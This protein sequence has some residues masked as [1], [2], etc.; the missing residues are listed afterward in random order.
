MTYFFFRVPQEFKNQPVNCMNIFLILL[1]RSHFYFIYYVFW[2][3]YKKEI[4]QVDRAMRMNESKVISKKH[5]S[6]NI[7]S[8]WWKTHHEFYT[9][10]Y[11]FPKDISY[12]TKAIHTAC[13]FRSLYFHWKSNLV[14][15]DYVENAEMLSSRGKSMNKVDLW[16]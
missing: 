6:T 15:E 16:N 13:A 10:F 2:K 12:R 11:P 4:F 3:I 1:A 9:N 7:W 8:F 5:F 14:Q